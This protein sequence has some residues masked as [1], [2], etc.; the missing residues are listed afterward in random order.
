MPVV[1]VP[2]GE[3]FVLAL[4]QIEPY[5]NA[6][7]RSAAKLAALIGRARSEVGPDRS[8][9]VIV[10]EVYLQHYGAFDPRAPGGTAAQTA[11]RDDPAL[12]VVAA[13]AKEYRAAVI[14]TCALEHLP[15]DGPGLPLPRV[16][17][18]AD[19]GRSTPAASGG[20][21]GL[22][23]FNAAVAID[24]DG[25]VAAVYGKTHLWNGDGFDHVERDLYQASAEPARSV[26]W[27]KLPPPGAESDAGPE[28]S[29]LPDEPAPLSASDVYPVFTL[30]A[31]GLGDLRLGM[32]IC[33]DVE[34]P[35]VVAAY[36][37]RGVDVI[38]VP[39]ASTGPS[40]ILSR[41]LVPARAYEAHATI[42]YCNYPSNR[43]GEPSG[44]PVDGEAAA[45]GA[46]EAAAVPVRWAGA[47]DIAQAAAAASAFGN[48]AAPVWPLGFSGA[49]V[50]YDGDGTLAGEPS[51]PEAE[52]VTLVPV[53]G[54]GSARVAEHVQRNPY[55]ADRRLDLIKPTGLA[56]LQ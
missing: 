44:A 13:A 26:G 18:D 14:V 29:L 28:G 30:P 7:S 55:L 49:S 9:V 3:R 45:D 24:A 17:L 12:Q 22:L 41:V 48:A 4:C 37:A 8:L 10:P 54:P 23:P 50:V 51:P 52:S 11:Q 56:G 43:A 20:P 21:A 46:V 5:G 2:V 40:A 38:L 47:G 53:T 15:A 42:A 35:A 39:T 31:A 16:E 25:S 32:C 34:H 36:A 19:G 33:Y 1:T 6:P 27:R